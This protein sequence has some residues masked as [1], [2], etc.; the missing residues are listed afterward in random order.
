MPS[1]ASACGVCAGEGNRRRWVIV[2]SF[3]FV[4]AIVEIHELRSFVTT[5]RRD[6]V[7]DKPAA[8]INDSE[9]F[10]SLALIAI[11]RTHRISVL[12]LRVEL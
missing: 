12:K 4:S 9:A 3:D 6:T 10:P 1:H 7:R 8:G 5:R 2:R 11:K